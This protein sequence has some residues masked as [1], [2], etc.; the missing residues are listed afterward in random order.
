MSI[1]P[2]LYARLIPKIQY[3]SRPY[4]KAND[5]T[6]AVTKRTSIMHWHDCKA[7][8]YN[9]NSIIENMKI[10]IH[11]IRNTLTTWCI[12]ATGQLYELITK[13]ILLYVA[14]IIDQF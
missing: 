9:N 10:R 7:D 11:T 5:K 2:S 1:S 13:L 8:A 6:S 12:M 4:E 3:Q 14:I